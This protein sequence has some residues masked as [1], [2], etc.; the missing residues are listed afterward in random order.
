MTT[1]AHFQLCNAPE[2]QYDYG[3]KTHCRPSSTAP[4]LTLVEMTIVLMI[5]LAL[6]STGVMTF[7]NVRDWKLG[8]LASESLRTV[9]S[10][11][12]MFLADHPTRLV[13]TITEADI[14]PY[15]PGDPDSLPTVKSLDDQDLSIIV[16]EFPPYFDD[17]GGVR[18]DPSGSTSDSLWDVGE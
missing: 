2:P 11:Q 1:D 8:R 14:L 6:I 12:R 18:Y 10:A 7:N 4:G 17:S 15:M 5:L 16:S 9:H 13:A 3:M